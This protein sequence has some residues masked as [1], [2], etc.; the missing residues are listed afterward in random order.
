MNYAQHLLEGMEKL[1]APKVARKA[2][3]TP[4]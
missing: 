4:S 3:Q 1:V 2:K